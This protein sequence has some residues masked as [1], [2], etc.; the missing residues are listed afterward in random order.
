M[1]TT[2]TPK[3]EPE[4]RNV[5][6]KWRDNAWYPRIVIRPSNHRVSARGLSQSVPQ[7][8]E[9]ERSQCMKGRQFDKAG[10]QQRGSGR[11]RL[12][13]S[14]IPFYLRSRLFNLPSSDNSL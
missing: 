14:T 13:A 1:P 12:P 2:S 8:P 7:F 5:P 9:F 11:C 10:R 6:V 4:K 3:P